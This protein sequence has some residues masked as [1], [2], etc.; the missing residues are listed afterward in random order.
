MGRRLTRDG[1]FRMIR[2]DTAPTTAGGGTACRAMDESNPYKP[3]ST[4]PTDLEEATWSALSI[5]VLIGLNVVATLVACVVTF[6]PESIGLFY[7][8]GLFSISIP[9]GA[10]CG[11][12]A[13]RPMRA[14]VM[15]DLRRRK[16]KQQASNK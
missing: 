11:W 2:A 16:K 15:W 5:S 9:L 10:V 6:K 12:L 7:I 8:V 3:P 14:Y 1:H 4:P 13:F